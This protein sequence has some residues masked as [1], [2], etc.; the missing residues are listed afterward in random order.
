M[1]DKRDNP[2]DHSHSDYGGLGRTAL[3]V[4]LLAIMLIIVQVIV[5]TC[6]VYPEVE[7][8]RERYCQVAP[9]DKD[10]CKVVPR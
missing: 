6:V 8:L 4:A 2:S 7:H 1:S 3:T 5:Q 10:A 9:A